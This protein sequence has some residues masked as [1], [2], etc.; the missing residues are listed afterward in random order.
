[1]TVSFDLKKDLLFYGEVMWEVAFHKKDILK[2]DIGIKIHRMTFYGIKVDGFNKKD[3]LIKDILN[4][5]KKT[6]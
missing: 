1:V 6:D 5:L 4:E 3:E 2:F